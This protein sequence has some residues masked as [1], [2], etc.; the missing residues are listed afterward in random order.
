MRVTTFII[1]FLTGTAGLAQ[2][3][4]SLDIKIGQMLLIGYPGPELDS[5]VLREIKDGKVGSII[6]FEKNV[7]KSSTA[8][9]TLKKVLW[10]Y[11]KAAPIPLLITID[12]EG[13]RVNRLKDKYGF[14][15]SIP[16]RHKVRRIPSTLCDSTQSLLHQT[17]RVSVSMST[18]RRLLMWQ[19]IPRTR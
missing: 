4:D 14:P 11:Q 10:T 9:Y 16:L 6:L 7:P 19:L 2:Q 13:G 3:R 15:K 17:W 18:L 8:F 5:T 12:Q 1:L